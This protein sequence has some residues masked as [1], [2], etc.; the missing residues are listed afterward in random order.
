MT[1]TTEQAKQ[2]YD[3]SAAVYNDYASVPSGL[4]ECEL[5]EHALGNCTGLSIL[6]LGG[7]TGLHARQAMD[8]GA[9][10]VDVV[11]ISPKMLEIGENI[12][13]SLRGNNKKI[14]YYE[15]DVSKPVSHLPLRDGGYDIV[16]ANWVFSFADSLELLEGMFL[17]ITK[18]LKPGGRFIGVRDADP[19][20][21]YLQTGKYGA[22][23]K[24]VKAIPGG[25]KYLCVLHS[26]PPI[27]FE[28]SSLEVI[29]SGSTE[30]YEKF[31]LVDVEVVPYER[32]EVTRKDPEFWKDFLERPCFAVVTARKI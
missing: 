27:E 10:I 12:E 1:S 13:T 2:E 17:N 7:G 32:A 24:W 30:M 5:I 31:G 15:A 14:N 29:Y 11:D 28:S 9:S 23:V 8:L 22:S 21:P 6:D 4:I 20:S 18:N 3:V 19:G 25:V 16:M 26:S